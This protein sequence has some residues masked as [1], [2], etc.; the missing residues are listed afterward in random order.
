MILLFCIFCAGN[1]VRALEN[2]LE[3]T[4]A[5]KSWLAKKLRV[6]VR[7]GNWPPFMFSDDDFRGISVDYIEKIFARHNIEYEFVSDKVI[8]W[9]EALVSI[10]KHQVIDLILT[11][12]ITDKRKQTMLFTD[13]YLFLPWI[14]FART[15][16][17]FIGDIGDLEG[18][19]VCVPDGYVM[20]NLLTKNYPQISLHVLSGGS[21]A[22]RCLQALAEGEVDAYVGNLAVGS[23][24]IQQRGYSNLKVAAPTPFG[25]HN[26][27]MAVRDDWPE[28][29]SII[30]KSLDGFTAQE[31]AAIR[32][33]WLSVRY[34]H[35]IRPLDVI[36]WVLGVAAFL[37]ALLFVI[38]LWNRRLNHEILQRKRIEEELQYSE[39]R[40]KTLSD[41]AFEGIIISDKGA[42]LDA[43]N[44]VATMTGYTPEELLSMQSI[45]LVAPEQR[46]EIQQKI[47]SGYEDSYEVT[48]LR[49]NGSTFPVLVQ[50]K[51]FSYKGKH[52]RVAA[53]R[54]LTR[55]KKAEEEIKTLQGIIPICSRCKKIRD[56]KGYWQQVDRYIT[57]HSDAV[58]SHGMCKNCS[59]ELYG[60]EKWYD[61]G[62]KDI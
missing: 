18:R 21:G 23:Y 62:Q 26:Q 53:I 61:E 31:H 5:E 9:S 59:D 19:K 43:N 7:V 17:Q 25:T 28:L 41:A 48:I 11:A 47:V 14:I 42:I 49:K 29:V 60:G 50:G 46:D 12:K 51:M 22:P 58:F 13:E 55:R 37:I 27:A 52:V 32:N 30:N 24:I 3:Y 56:D 40:Y 15:D 35:G 20:H 2:T 6:R 1:N 33:K 34:E 54:D 45:D 16:S 44:T 4:P 10:G 38:T 57:E 8:P 36:A 39:G